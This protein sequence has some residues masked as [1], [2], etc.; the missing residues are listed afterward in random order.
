MQH[1]E[2]ISVSLVCPN[3]LAREGLRRILNEHEFEVIASWGSIDLI[4]KNSPATV[5]GIIIIDCTSLGSCTEQVE[6]VRER[7][8]LAK[9]VFLSDTFSLAHMMEAFR[10]GVDGYVL[11][12]IGCDSLIESLRLVRLGEKVMPSELVRHL[13][14]HAIGSS[15]STGSEANFAELL[16]EREIETLRC[17]VLGIPNKV[18][19]YRLDI[20]E[21]TVKVHVKAVLRKLMVQNR[22]QA[23]I[24]AVNHGMT[25]TQMDGLTRPETALLGGAE[26]GESSMMERSA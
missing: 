7:F 19:A 15:P 17:L 21:A 1:A 14:Q 25:P 26:I 11:K 18:I 6:E 3:D 16:S 23:A 4:I 9:I 12:E 22:T 5:S 24:W 10:A 8:P 2:P 13:P 20:S